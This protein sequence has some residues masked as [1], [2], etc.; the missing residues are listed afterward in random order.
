[1]SEPTAS[2]EGFCT[3]H[4]EPL[5][6]LFSELIESGQELGASLAVTVDG[7]FALDLWGR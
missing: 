6:Q 3:P 2:V 4:F 1:M 5:R 7:E